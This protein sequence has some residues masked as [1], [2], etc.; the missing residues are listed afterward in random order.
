MIMGPLFEWGKNKRRV[1]IQ[2]AE[3]EIAVNNYLNTY[4]TALSDVEN[5]LVSIQSYRD[6][7][8]A[9]M[10]QVIAARKALMLTR[11]KYDSGYSSYLEVLIAESYAFDAE[12]LASYTRGQQLTATVSLYRALG[13]GW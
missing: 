5:A 6:E 4:R 8:T 7:Y 12:M 3:A 10:R 13:G 2:R 9:R 11:A 1:D